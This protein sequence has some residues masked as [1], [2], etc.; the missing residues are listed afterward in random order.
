MTQIL[1][2][3]VLIGTLFLSVGVKPKKVPVK[4]ETIHRGR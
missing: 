3:A 2:I 4:N 1:A